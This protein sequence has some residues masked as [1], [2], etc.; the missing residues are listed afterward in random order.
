MQE[1]GKGKGYSWMMEIIICVLIYMVGVI[2][3]SFGQVTAF[4]AYLLR[5]SEYVRMIRSGEQDIGKIMEL[6]QDMPEWMLIFM[7]YSEILLI[8]TYF[9]YCR[10]VDRR[11]VRSF[12]FMKEGAVGQYLKGILVG[13]AAFGAA[14]LLCLVTGSVRWEGMSANLAPAYI[15]FYLG[16]YMIQGMAEEVICRGYLL[17]SVSRK[18]S[19]MFASVVSSFVFMLL[20]FANDGMTVL[21]A[22]NLFLFGMFMAF[23]FVESGNIWVVGAVH[24]I[25][26]FMEG[27]VLG[28]QVSGL[29]K[30]TSIF[31]TSCIGGR[32]LIHGGKFGMEGGL[33]VTLVLVVALVW[34]YRRMEQ[35][36][37]LVEAEEQTSGHRENGTSEGQTQIYTDGYRVY[38]NDP[39]EFS[40]TPWR[41][42]AQQ[43]GGK[44]ECSEESKT[45]DDSRE[46]ADFKSPD[47]PKAM[48]DQNHTGD[49]GQRIKQTIFDARYFSME[50][51]K[52]DEE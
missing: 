33:A 7:L 26:N 38:K 48:D 36:G 6:M 16:G 37:M 18:Y 31:V 3:M 21:S 44:A 46:L 5:D 39:A 19:V 40:E 20:H 35:K 47:K 25:W 22:V 17:V 14:Y 24:S 2:V 11:S 12:G 4:S 51:E 1:N 50:E 52:K 23:L 42:D 34:L 49:S 27:N 32:S 45:G 13:V 43:S 29:Q 28:V 8:L 9:L 41:P 15:V 10:F 30:Q